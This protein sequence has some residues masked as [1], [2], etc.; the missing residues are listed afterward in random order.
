MKYLHSNA[1]TAFKLFYVLEIRKVLLR[2]QNKL[3][4]FQNEKCEVNKF[5]VIAAKDWRE[6]NKSVQF[7]WNEIKVSVVSIY[8]KYI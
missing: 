2:N 7:K 4:R 8:S 1:F 3:I 5:P 6:I